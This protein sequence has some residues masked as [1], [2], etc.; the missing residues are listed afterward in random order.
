[1]PRTAKPTKKSGFLDGILNR[2]PP[3]LL[4]LL[5][6]L[7]LVLIAIILGIAVVQG[8]E[9]NLFGVI[10][11]PAR[12]SQ[13]T[14]DSSLVTNATFKLRLNPNK[15]NPRDPEIEIDR[16]SINEQ[17]EEVRK[18]VT[19]GVEDGMIYVET[20]V[21]LNTRFFFEIKTSKGTFTT[22]NLSLTSANLVAH[23]I[24]TE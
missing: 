20:N 1:M 8:R 19:K 4:S 10:T 3:K 18:Q 15:I 12:G 16:V 14:Q 17:G 23:E 21:D 24:P 2:L 9:V 22:D 5:I 13:M 6:A 11:I 7:A